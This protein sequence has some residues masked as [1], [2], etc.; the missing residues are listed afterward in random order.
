MIVM[1]ASTALFM[2]LY[3]YNMHEQACQY[4]LSSSFMAGE[5]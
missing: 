5:M 2:Y 1:P 3:E 4:L